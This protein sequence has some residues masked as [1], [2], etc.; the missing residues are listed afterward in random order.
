M[1]DRQQQPGVHR[2]L[3]ALA[4]S[5][6]RANALLLSSKSNM[7]A[8]MLTSWGAHNVATDWNLAAERLGDRV[9]RSCP[10]W[11]VLLEAVETSTACLRPVRSAFHSSL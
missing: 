3:Q 11:L 2:E 9:L 6:A 1:P 4:A 5:F 8:F 10:R 7:G